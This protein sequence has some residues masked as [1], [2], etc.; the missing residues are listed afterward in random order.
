VIGC[1]AVA[2]SMI[3]RRAVSHSFKHGNI[4]IGHAWALPSSMGEGQ[5]FM[6]LLNAG[7]SVERLV[8]ARTDNAAVVELRRNNHYSD[9]PEDAFELAPMKP[10]PMRPTAYH[11]RLVGLQRPLRVGDLFNM[12]LDFEVAGEV[13]IEVYVET[14]PGD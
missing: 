5:V 7:T 4:S 10:F 8:T 14:A 11:L 9:P 1:G 6:P 2:A 12:V 13:D 3:P